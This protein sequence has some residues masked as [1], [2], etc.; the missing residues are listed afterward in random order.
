MVSICL[1]MEKETWINGGQ[2]IRHAKSCPVPP[3]RLK[4][5][6]FYETWVSY[7]DLH[8]ITLCYVRKYFEIL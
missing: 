3:S 2:E 5:I 7:L 8:K 6:I 4:Q 1:E